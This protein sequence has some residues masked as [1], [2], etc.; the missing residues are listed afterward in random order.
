VTRAGIG[1][2]AHAFEAGGDRPLV[3]G[4]VTIPDHPGLAGH[5][6]ADVLSHA[7]ADALLGAAALGDLGSLFPSNDRWKDASSLAILEETARLVTQA[8]YRIVHVDA[9]VVAQA[10]RLAPYRDA[11]RA[12]VAAALA[13]P[14]D[15]VSVKAT[16]TDGLGFTGR[17]E[18][19]AALAA[20]TI[21]PSART[22]S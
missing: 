3:I 10:P 13:L 19:I 17:G 12:N 15:D 4:G 18:G 5:S 22:G 16:T 8:G 11:M 9:S 21:E 20:A 1:F 7:I 6:D 14:V 2:D